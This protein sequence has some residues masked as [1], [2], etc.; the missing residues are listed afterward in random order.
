VARIVLERATR[1]AR[2]TI[3]E[4]GRMA[5]GGG[6]LDLDELLAEAPGQDR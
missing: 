5:R 1:P 3:D 2:G 6:A 4:H